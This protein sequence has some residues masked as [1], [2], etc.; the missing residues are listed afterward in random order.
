M[1][2]SASLAAA[3]APAT[4]TGSAPF[5]GAS[6]DTPAHSARASDASRS[7]SPGATSS[8]SRRRHAGSAS[9]I[10]RTVSALFAANPSIAA[11]RSSA[12]RSR[13]TDSAQSRSIRSG[14]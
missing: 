7:R 12:A 3:F 6:F 4:S 8:A 1:T 9:R 11:T 10:A 5:D 2:S 13:T 14:R